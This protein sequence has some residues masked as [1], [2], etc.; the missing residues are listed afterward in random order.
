MRVVA[1]DGQPAQLTGSS[2]PIGQDAP[3]ADRPLRHEQLSGIGPPL[4]H[5]D[6]LVAI[7]HE[8]V[9]IGE[10]RLGRGDRARGHEARLDHEPIGGGAPGLRGAQASAGATRVGARLAIDPDVGIRIRARVARAH[11]SMRE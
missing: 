4:R 7:D 1:L 9:A 6:D 8:R 3:V 2:G 10:D 11:A 5:R